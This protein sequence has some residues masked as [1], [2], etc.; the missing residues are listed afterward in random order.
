MFNGTVSIRTKTGDEKSKIERGEAPVWSLSWSPNPQKDEDILAITDW[1]QKLSFYQL[2]GKQIGKDRHLGYDPC[3]VSYFSG[4]DYLVVG[5]SDKKVSLWTPEG[6]RIGVVCERDHWVWAAKMKSKQN[7]V[8]VGCQDGTVSIYQIVF[9][10]VHGLYHDRYAYRENMTDVVIQHL[11]TEQRARIKCR[12]HV[13]KISVYKDRLAVQ[14]TDRVIVYE[15]FHDDATDMHYRIKEKIQKKLDCN[16]LV[17]TSLHIIL[18]MESKLQMYNFSGE[19]EREWALDSLI[20]YIKVVGG[21]VGKEGLLVG[22]KS[23]HILQIFVDNAFPISLIKHTTSIRC[24][25]ISMNRKKIAVVDE[26]STFLVY[27]LASKELVYQEPNANSVA[28]NMEY[29]DM[30]CYSGNGVLNIKAGSFPSH[31]QSMQGFVVGFKGSRIFC[32]HQSAMTT[33]DVP[34]SAT[35]EKYLEKNNY[36]D[37]YKLACLGVT[38]GDWR[39]LA[40]EALESLELEIAKKAF[41]RLRDLKY[42]D[43]IRG[44]EKLSMDTGKLD[45]DLSLADVYALSGKYLDVRFL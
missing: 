6:I 5:G 24:L 25:D 12:D 10:T 39:K 28:W 19:K 26:Q 17:V 27:D 31:Q 15:L 16:L 37:A 7:F 36:N 13:K 43:L 42:I 38:E 29:E 22:L 44:I 33:I 32:L 20:R 4:G 14:L 1:G 18:C 9:N 45:P 30:V 11:S 21:P 8:A 40:M 2:S 23:G 3:S 34:H 35:L 41:A